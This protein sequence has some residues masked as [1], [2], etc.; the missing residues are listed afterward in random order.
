MGADIVNGNSSLK[1]SFKGDILN[2][3]KKKQEGVL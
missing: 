3:I 2:N 1:M